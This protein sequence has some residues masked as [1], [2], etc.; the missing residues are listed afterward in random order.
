[1]GR[2]SNFTTQSLNRFPSIDGSAQAM[3]VF[4]PLP[5][6]KLRLRVSFSFPPS[7]IFSI[8]K[9]GASSASKRVCLLD[10]T[11]PYWLP[12]WA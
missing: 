10:E 6:T 9:T 4:Q 1:M 7:P 8:P 11:L 3:I 2:A 12:G 5:R